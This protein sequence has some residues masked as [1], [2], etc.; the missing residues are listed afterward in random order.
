MRKRRFAVL[1]RIIASN[2][3]PAANGAVNAASVAM[4]RAVRL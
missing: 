4:A 2:T 3:K 1:A